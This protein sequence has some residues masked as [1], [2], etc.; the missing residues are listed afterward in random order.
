[1]LVVPSCVAAGFTF[2]WSRW[3]APPPEQ[4]RYIDFSSVIADDY[5]LINDAIRRTP[6]R[7]R[8]LLGAGDPRHPEVH[9]R[10]H[11]NAMMDANLSDP[12]GRSPPS[13]H[14]LWCRGR[15]SEPESGT[16]VSGRGRQS[17]CDLLNPLE[18]ALRCLL[19]TRVFVVG[20]TWSLRTRCRVDRD[21]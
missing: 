11:Q 16:S 13:S 12:K 20:L 10:L 19:Q 17:L 1:M 21:D 18:V 15:G 4:S 3:G 6:H 7:L 5:S 2:T 14:S 8:R 9:G